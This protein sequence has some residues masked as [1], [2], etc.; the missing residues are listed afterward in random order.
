M[1]QFFSLILIVGSFYNPEFISK[2]KKILGEWTII[3]TL[4]IEKI[5]D[6]L[7]KEK[8]SG[9]IDTMKINF[10][11]NNIATA[12][13]NDGKVVAD[14][15][16]KI[17]HGKIQIIYNGDHSFLQKLNGKFEMKFSK[18]TKLELVSENNN[19]IFFER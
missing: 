14:L 9:L 13:G 16:W 4:T 18:K 8:T 5:G 11:L 2:E 19:S 1:K 15:F 3:K 10:K 7:Y 12:S 17:D 6:N